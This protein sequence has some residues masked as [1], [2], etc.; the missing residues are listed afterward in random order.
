MEHQ[1]DSNIQQEQRDAP[2]NIW[3]AYCLSAFLLTLLPM[4]WFTYVEASTA[5]ELGFGNLRTAPRPCRR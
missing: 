3:A 1:K 4:C 2:W 5:E